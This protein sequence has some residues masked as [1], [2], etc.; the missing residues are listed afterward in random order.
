LD[1][2]SRTAEGRLNR[3]TCDV[4]LLDRFCVVRIVDGCKNSVAKDVCNN[5]FVVGILEF[6]KMEGWMNMDDLVSRKETENTIRKLL[7]E[8]AINCADAGDPLDEFY[9]DIAHNRLETWISL[10]P[11]APV[12]VPLD[13]LCERLADIAGGKNN[14]L[15]IEC[16]GSEG[17]KCPDENCLCENP[18]AWKRHLTKWMEGLDAAD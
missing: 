8:T 17:A 14:T 9:A 1:A 11:A 18:D 7:M 5:L 13:K 6:E 2:A 3:E 16:C 4:L 12:S 15:C 10:I